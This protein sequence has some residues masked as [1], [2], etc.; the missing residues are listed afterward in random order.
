MSFFTQHGN[1]KF[2]GDWKIADAEYSLL[3]RIKPVLDAGVFTV[4]SAEGDDAIT[5][6]VTLR[7]QDG[8]VLHF[9]TENR[10]V[11]IGVDGYDELRAGM[12]DHANKTD[13]DMIG[14]H[15]SDKG[16]ATF[17]NMADGGKMAFTNA[18]GVTSCVSLTDG[19]DRRHIQM[20]SHDPNG[21]CT[22]VAINPDGVYYADSDG[23]DFAD[24]NRI[25]RIKDLKNATIEL[26]EEQKRMLK[27][28]PGVQGPAGSDGKSAKIG[29]ITVE[30]ET[31]EDGEAAV[32]VAANDSVDETTGDNTKNLTFK[33]RIPKGDRGDAG[34]EGPAGRDGK[35]GEVTVTVNTLESADGAASGTAEVT[36]D[37]ETGKQNMTFTFSLPRGPQGEQGVKGEDGKDGDPGPPGA[38]GEAGAPN[39]LS[40]GT[41]EF[42]DSAEEGAVTVE[43]ESPV[44]KLSF[45]IPR[46]EPGAAGQ[47]GQPGEKGRDAKIGNVTVTV[48]TAEPAGSASGSASVTDGADG[49]QDIAFT[50]Q[51]PKGEQGDRGIQGE[52]G[53]DG[54]SAGF[55]KPTTSVQTLEADQNAT[56]EVTVD[57][58]SPDTAKVFQF[59]FG[60]PKGAR[61][62]GGAETVSVRKPP[63]LFTCPE[64]EKALYLIVEY[65]E[66]DAEEPTYRTLVDTRLTQNIHEVYCNAGGGWVRFV[67]G[68]TDGIES[69]FGGWPVMVDTAN[70]SEIDAS[71][72]YYIRYRWAIRNGG[73]IDPTAWVDSVDD[74]DYTFSDWYHMVYPCA[75]E[76]PVS[77]GPSTP[78]PSVSDLKE[79]SV[80][81]FADGRYTAITLEELSEKLDAVKQAGA[82]RTS[83]TAPAA[84]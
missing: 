73:D 79:N 23:D 59:S 16:A 3:E 75:T 53:K 58:N 55:G 62:D 8:C 74:S 65:A 35:I 32:E 38:Q 69:P 54:V 56:A 37:G 45:K 82:A 15:V 68:N 67:T 9:D 19:S 2:V 70:V 7:T 43:G 21:S 66:A 14:E 34:P 10:T 20:Y 46:G 71:K 81:F 29:A 84:E 39:V 26:S 51:L 76:A 36:D 52:N 27:G 57:E 11:T 18:S 48:T 72:L 60:I 42:V 22:R 4:R 44:Q 30:T 47:N 24:G 25:A 17:R 61:G 5:G 64:N 13:L 41:V 1:I 28:E 40:I 33:F 77:S 78:L 31:A 12:H 63:L 80:L 49:A 83:G 50:L 6:G